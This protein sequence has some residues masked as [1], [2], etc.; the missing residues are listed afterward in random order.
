[1]PAAAGGR[2]RERARRLRGLHLVV[3]DRREEAVA[4]GQGGW[5]LVVFEVGEVGAVALLELRRGGGGGGG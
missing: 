2:P 1:M 4:V 3:E 5:V